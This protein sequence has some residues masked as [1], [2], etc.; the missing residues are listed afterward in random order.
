MSVLLAAG[1]AQSRQAKAKEICRR[2]GYEPMVISP[3]YFINSLP[4]SLVIPS[5]CAIGLSMWVSVGVFSHCSRET[6]WH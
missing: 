1:Q 6:F 2:R 5:K 4:Y 3:S